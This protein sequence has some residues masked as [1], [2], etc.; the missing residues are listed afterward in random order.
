MSIPT[1][2]EAVAPEPGSAAYDAKMVALGETLD[3][4]S[5]P[6]DPPED[7]PAGDRPVW[8]PEKFKSPEDMAKAYAELENKQSK[9][10]A[11]PTTPEAAAA[12]S[13][14]EAAAVLEGAGLNLDDYSDEY[15]RT[16]SLAED[17]YAKLA[18]AGVS[19]Q[20]VDGYI[21]GQQA[22]ANVIRND[23]FT[24]VGGED[25]YASM[26]GWAAKSLPASDVAAYNRAM[27]SRDP[28]LA[29]LAVAGLHSKFT[30]ANPAEPKL[31]QGATGAVGAEGFESSQ[32]VVV[33]MRDPRYKVDPAY[34][35]SV[36]RR[37][38]NSNVF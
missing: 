19:K 20:L 32:Q 25:T 18:K 27:D 10:P 26:M 8:L 35:K 11:V 36:D 1:T 17:S 12:A 14:G 23:V 29:K 2:T 34:R 33:A 3:A 30:T 15:L 7:T 13:T 5:D 37:L 31:L 21:A 28:A 16:G 22:Q 4:P 38:T 24:S 6:V 9:P